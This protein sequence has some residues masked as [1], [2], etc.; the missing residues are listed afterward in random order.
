M[1]SVKAISMTLCLGAMSV[2]ATA[3]VVCPASVVDVGTRHALINA[4]LFDGPPEQ[5]AD[6]VPEP[7]GRVD[8]WNLDG[9]DPYLVCKYKN[10]AKTITLHAP[11]Q[12]VC[13]AGNKPFQ[14][15]C[16]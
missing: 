3:R 11:T 13:E 1:W 8:R 6:L 15:Y 14:A 16:R 10:T 9:V 4:S 2:S 12:K 7:A 5:E